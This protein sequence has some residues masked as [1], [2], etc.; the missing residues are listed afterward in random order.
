MNLSSADLSE[1]V[2]LA[3]TAATEAGQMIVESRPVA[4]EHKPGAA[5]LASQVVTEVDRRS[6][7]IILN[8]LN[9]TLERFELALL[10]EEQADDHSRLAA[11]YFWCIDPLDGTLPFIEGIPGYSVAIALVGRDGTPVVG[12]VYDPVEETTLHAVSGGGAFRDRYPWRPET[13]PRDDVLTVF[14]D[15]SFLAYDNHDETVDA[16]GQIAHEMG[17][18]GMRLEATRGGVLN[19]C[20]VLANPLA[21]YVKFPRPSGGGSLWD[22]AATACLFNEAGAVATDIHGDPLDLNRADSTN[23]NHQGVLFATDEAL[24]EKLGAL[25]S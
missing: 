17:L 19:A 21:C 10:T 11:D 18:S 16:L 14:A 9:P 25:R 24:A 4:V 23:M 5:S 22:F 3:I 2:D 12:V 1:L 6:E 13:T 7:D 8:V 15:R 20:A